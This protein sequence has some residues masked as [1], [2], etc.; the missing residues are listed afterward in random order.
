[1]VALGA[2]ALA[3]LLVATAA[4]SVAAA[5]TAEDTGGAAGAE[6]LTVS[7]ATVDANETATIEV[8]LEEAPDGLA[9][10]EVTLELDAPSVANVT[11][12]SYPSAYG[13]TTD[14][15]IGRDGDAVTLEAID[16]DDE[17]EPG[18]TDV[19]LA[20]VAVTGATSGTTD[21]EV[22]DLQ[23]D[24]DDGSRIQP[25]RMAGFLDVRPL[26]S[27]GASGSAIGASSGDSAGESAG[28]PG[29]APGDGVI[30]IAGALAMLVVVAVATVAARR[31]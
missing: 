14:P 21:V 24:A 10:F 27:G 1:M 19:T 30:A 15:R 23:I 29:I 6:R 11:G 25:T 28:V 7:N 2:A 5:S 3:L 17:V 4:P 18:A 8:T 20:T 9:G 31:R 13:M 16:L 12:A 22:S 26:T